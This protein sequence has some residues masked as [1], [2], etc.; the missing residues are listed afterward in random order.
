MTTRAPAPSLL[1]L[2]KR[3]HRWL[4]AAAILR[5]A[6]RAGAAIAV[7][8]TLAALIG[9]PAA[10]GPGLASLRL[11]LA[12]LA[13]L[14]LLG[15]GVLRARSASPPFDRFLE[16]AEERLPGLRSL[17]RNAVDLESAGAGHG[18]QELADALREQAARSVADAHLESL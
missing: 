2:L 16:S 4:R 11:A 17:L 10:M 7:V 8:I 15:L 6:L 9:W 13:A 14:V 3:H 18:S 5:H 1:P 12:S